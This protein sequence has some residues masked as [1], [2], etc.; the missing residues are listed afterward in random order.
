MSPFVIEA[1]HYALAVVDVDAAKRKLRRTLRSERRALVERE[2]AAGLERRSTRIIR[3][4]V[5]VDAV[6]DARRVLSYRAI[7]GEV[8]T[9]ALA[10]WCRE[11][12][13]E[14]R[15][16][17]AHPDAEPPVEVG[18]PD[19]VVVP[20]LAVTT[21]GHRLGQGGGW[22]DRFLADRPPDTVAISPIYREFL[23][24]EVPQEAHDSVLDCVVSDDAA[25][26]VA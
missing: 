21:A 5:D 10:T 16:T 11:R 24:D 2:G 15:T 9:V 8:E 25:W 1:R 13:V 18:W 19:V 7:P 6:R 22:Y 17:E 14:L 20:S 26:W 23:L 3:R 4:L 12:G